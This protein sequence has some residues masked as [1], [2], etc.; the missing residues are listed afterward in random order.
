M[1]YTYYYD[2]IDQLVRYKD[3]ETPYD[4]GPN[5]GTWNAVGELYIASMNKWLKADAPQN[6]E[7]KYSG[8]FHV[9]SEG[10]STAQAIDALTG[11]LLDRWNTTHQT[12]YR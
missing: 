12:T 3:G 5:A 9:L 2:G 11:K 6:V 7:V 8:N 1:S 4:D 10:Q